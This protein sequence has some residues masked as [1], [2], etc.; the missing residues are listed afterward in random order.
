MRT[1]TTLDHHSHNWRTLHGIKILWR[2][3]FKWRY[4]LP[5]HEST[6]HCTKKNMPFHI[7]MFWYY[8]VQISNGSKI[9]HAF[10]SLMSGVLL[11]KTGVLIFAA[12]VQLGKRSLHHKDRCTNILLRLI[13]RNVVSVLHLPGTSGEPFPQI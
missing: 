8:L 5:I 13:F 11:K 4:Q 3:W 1:C 10:G 7:F 9:E 6:S 12:S 2:S